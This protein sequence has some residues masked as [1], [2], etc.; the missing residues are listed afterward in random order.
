MLTGA[1]FGAPLFV[2]AAIIG[3]HDRATSATA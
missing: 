2:A 1:R 3:P